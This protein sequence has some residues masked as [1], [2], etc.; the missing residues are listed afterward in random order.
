M[1]RRT[2]GVLLLVTTCLAATAAV[3]G[4]SSM[5]VA[6]PPATIPTGHLVAPAAAPAGT[7]RNTY[8]LDGPEFYLAP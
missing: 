3:S 5:T 8:S 2:V 7:L 4:C 1:T 6:A